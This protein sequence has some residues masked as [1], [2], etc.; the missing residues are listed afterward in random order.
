MNARIEKGL[1]AFEVVRVRAC[2]YV[3]L[4]YKLTTTIGYATVLCCVLMATGPTQN[5][6]EAHERGKATMR[7]GIEVGDR[8][9]H[10]ELRATRLASKRLRRSF[11]CS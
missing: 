1:S 7:V 10:N 5:S 6:G 9:V 3:Q 4:V 2:I 11:W 8:R